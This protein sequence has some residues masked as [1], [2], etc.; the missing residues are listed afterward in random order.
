[1]LGPRGLN[2]NPPVRVRP[3][4][5]AGGEHCPSADYYFL[6]F[7]RLDFFAVVVRDFERD[8]LLDVCRLDLGWLLTFT[9]ERRASESPMATACLRLLAAPFPRFIL[10]ICS[11]T[12]SPACVEAD[13]PWRLSA[14]ARFFVVAV[15]IFITPFRLLQ[16]DC[17]VKISGAWPEYRMVQRLSAAS[18]NACE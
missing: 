8:E 15:G 3:P 7:E 13:F 4:L 17:G 1:M 16:R 9:P 2:G 10:C 12:Y 5:W 18:V 11:C 14:W 6:D